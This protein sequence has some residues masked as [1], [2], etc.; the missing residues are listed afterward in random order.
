MASPVRRAA[1]RGL[2]RAAR[3]LVYSPPVRGLARAIQDAP[4]ARRLRD[5]LE[6]R[7]RGAL[8]RRLAS[9]PLPAGHFYAR[10]TVVD[11]QEHRGQ[12]FQLRERG[13]IVYGNRIEAPPTGAPLE[14]RNIL[15]TSDDPADF[16]LDIPAEHRLDIGRGAF[17]TDEQDGFDRRYGVERLGDLF[18]SVRGNTV[19]P[20][21]LII[22]F[23]GFPPA[24]SRI[25]YAVSYLKA[26]LDEDLAETMMLCVQDRYGVAGTYLVHDNAGRPVLD[27]L[28]AAIDDLRARHGIAEEDVLLF[29]A[30]KGASIAVMAAQ[31]LPR[32]R[33][34]LV[35]PQMDVPYYCTKSV[36]RGGL[37]RDRALRE[38][39]QP[40]ALLRRYLAEGRRIDYFYADA[41]ESSNVS[42][43]E[44]ARDAEGLTK[45][46]IGGEHT[47]VARRSLPT[48][49]SLLR[50]FAAGPADGTGTPLVSDGTV[51][52][53]GAGG[54]GAA[55]GTGAGDAPGEPL[56]CTDLTLTRRG[57]AMIA[58]VQ[59]ADA[60][61]PEQVNVYL[62][63]WLG[64]TRFRQLLSTGTDPSARWT[65][66]DQRLDPAL[67]PV[68]FTR[69]LAFD[70]TERPR[71]A[72]LPAAAGSSAGEDADGG[73]DDAR[74]PRTPPDPLTC[75][76][77]EPREYAL[78]TASCAPS[79]RVLYVS[80]T[81]DRGSGIAELHLAA[82][83]GESDASTGTPA[84]GADD[85][86]PARVRWTMAP[87]TGWRDLPQLVR[88]LA[89]ASEVEELRI[90][91]SDPAL[92][93]EQRHQLE[94]LDW[95]AVTV[96]DRVG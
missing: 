11:W 45:H 28:T 65:E 33:Q 54:T 44:Y 13:E 35:A 37:L 6:S 87:L 96:Q 32:A 80:E 71:V 82:R 76:A 64:R 78:L 59:F 30:S 5:A 86:A 22:T 27:R 3:D 91:V 85:G 31:G 93:A 24:N 58:R 21:R 53:G 70:G 14:Y 50:G 56:T 72:E 29:G 74:H 63:G 60:T 83:L 73:P 36:L 95:P 75:D 94:T 42:I 69:V 2:R 7:G 77:A 39:E 52:T 23:P 47:D 49:L 67:H 81:V 25:S 43:I 19:S 89:I 79:V 90:V 84:G 1:P 34:V 88:R 40:G 4:R 16:A 55:D 18:A 12:E 20:T 38:I 68:R 15:V 92:P 46:R 17:S 62:E 26:L 9:E 66:R 8:L 57:D 10:L 61:V 51:A 48:V 41:D